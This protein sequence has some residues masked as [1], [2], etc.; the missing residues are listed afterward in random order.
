MLPEMFNIV[1]FHI[2]NKRSL[3]QN[4]QGLENIKKHHDNRIYSSLRTKEEDVKIDKIMNNFV[5]KECNLDNI[6]DQL[7]PSE[8][9][10]I[11]RS[12]DELS[13]TKSW[14][15]IFPASNTQHLLQFISSPSYSDLILAAWEESFGT[16]WKKRE[17]G[18]ILQK[19]LYKEK[20]HLKVPAIMKVFST[21]FKNII[22][23]VC[24]LN[25]DLFPL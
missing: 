12:E 16:G 3:S 22:D 6:I 10:I 23:G 5:E 1:G 19:N 4:L 20:Y 9:R 25:M 11:L 18:Q 24:R 15:R 21:I 17:Q 2:P 7:L 13:Q 14:T 8:V